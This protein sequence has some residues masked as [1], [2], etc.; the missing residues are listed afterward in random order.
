[1]EEI[2]L[3]GIKLPK[4]QRHKKS[5]PLS[6]P[7]NSPDKDIWMTPP[8]L[9]FNIVKHFSPRIND[10]HFNFLEPCR[11]QGA[12][13]NA[14]RHFAACRAHEDS[15]VDWCELSEGRDFLEMRKPIVPQYH[16]LISNFPF[17]KYADF[18]EKSMQV[19]ENIVT[20]GTVCHV[21]SLRKRL[22][23]I[24][25]AGFFIREILYTDTPKEWRT[26]GF[27]CGAIYLNKQPG[28]CKISHL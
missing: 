7:K 14:M 17:S 4:K 22:R 3:G 25:E 10:S 20:Y 15:T 9:A 21:L 24:K 2:K 8:D 6:P 1:M 5:R 27:A 26:G 11:G 13:E 16:W 19:A 23:L 28:L 18:L 12:F